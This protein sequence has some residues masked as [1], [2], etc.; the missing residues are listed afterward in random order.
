MLV[1]SQFFKKLI[2]KAVYACK[3]LKVC[4]FSHLDSGIY[5]L[6]DFG[7]IT[8]PLFVTQLYLL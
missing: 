2:K 5:Q 8:S 3:C 7:P 6:C 4:L 1:I